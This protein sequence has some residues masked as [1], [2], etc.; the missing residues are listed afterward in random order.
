MEFF[1]AIRN[2]DA[3][4]VTRLLDADPSLIT[5]RQNGA[6]PLLFALY[7]GRAEIVRLLIERGAPVSFAEACALGDAGRALQLLERDPALLD[8]RSEDGY[9]P[10]GLAIFF[11]H[12]E[13]ARTLIERGAD[14]NAA[15]ENAQRVAPLHAAAAVMDRETVRLLLER[16]A[17]PN[18]RQDLD[19]A[20]L[21]TAA[22]RGDREMVDLLLAHGA[23][24]QPRSADGKS[25]ADVAREHGHEAFAEFLASQ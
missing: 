4:A 18:A 20:P 11:R 8:R 15:A 9:P 13:L 24:R 2:G 3:A 5:S 6:T 19:F 22:A 21:H 16:G 23:E 14:V 12:P 17:D 10:L 7:T 1:D 25:P